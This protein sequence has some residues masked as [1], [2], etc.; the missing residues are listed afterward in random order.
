MSRPSNLLAAAIAALVALPVAYLVVRG[1]G[2][3]AGLAALLEP[4]FG[5]L[6]ARSLGLAL[7]VGAIA[8]VL[9]LGLA[10]A[11]EAVDLPLRR[12][13]T[14]AVVLP[15]A[16]PSYVAATAYV[17]GLSPLGPF[18]ALLGALGVG[19][20]FP[21]GM[22][23]AVFVLVTST[24][25][26]AFLPLRAA[27]A[28]ADGDL[29]AA[30]RTLGRGRRAALATALRPVLGRAARGGFVV[31]VLYTLAE[32]GTVAILRVDV[33][34]RVIY[35]QFLSAFDRAAAAR[36]ALVLVALV[37]AVVVLAGGSRARTT[38]ADRGRPLRLQLGRA[39][40]LAVAA[41]AGYVAVAT[42]VPVVSLASWLVHTPRAGAG[43]GRAL[44]GSVQAA[45]IVVGPALAAAAIVA[46]AAERGGRVGRGL[47]RIVDT[48]YAL[49]GLVVALGLSVATLRLAPA[50]Y[51]TWVPYALAMLLLYAPLGATAIRG[52]LATVPPQLEEA[53]RTLGATRRGALWRVTLPIVRPGVLAAAA[54]IVIST[55][56]ELGASL[57][58]LPTGTTT[59]AVQLWDSTEEARY[60]HAAAP[61]LVLIA[62][63]GIAAFAIDRRRVV[64]GGA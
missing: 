35:H 59:L 23:W 25:P 53:A 7:V 57:L 8:T 19:P 58:M 5:V 60:G 26:L 42:V 12:A 6:V 39:R 56:K 36:S 62:L 10:V 50:L 24:V 34:P 43:L 28:R 63:A 20:V 32:L 11:V 18:G 30:A 46:I 51:Q 37:V 9:A 17:A 15:L 27:L 47:A 21:E 52:A 31:V 16:I 14:V 2:D 49:P 29:Y 54:L 1:A 41:I 38:L 48:G 22:A 13:A 64:G 55:M 44:A 45:L 61:A 40:W 4:G 3:R 33:L